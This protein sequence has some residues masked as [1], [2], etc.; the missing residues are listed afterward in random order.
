MTKFSFDADAQQ[1]IQRAHVKGD[2]AAEA[3]LMVAKYLRSGEPVPS[4]LAEYLAGAIEAAMVKD[5]N[6]RASELLIELGL[7]AKNR[8]EIEDWIKIGS[9]VEELLDSGKAKFNAFLDVAEMYGITDKTVKKYFN[10][11]QKTLK[12]NDEINNGER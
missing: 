11:Y 3:L 8:R 12:I 2:D 10:K 4:N 6:K 7:K 1:H 5:S 9:T